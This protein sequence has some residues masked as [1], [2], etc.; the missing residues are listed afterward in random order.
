[1][2]KQN[3]SDGEKFREWTLS[4]KIPL[5]VFIEKDGKWVFCDYFNPAGPMALRD[6][7]LP[8]DLSGLSPGKIRIKLESGTSFWEIDYLAIDYTINP[9]LDIKKLSLMS[10][11]NEKDEEISEL[12]MHDD[13]KYYVQSDNSNSARLSFQ[14]IEKTLPE[15]TIILHSKGYYNLNQESKGIPRIAKLKS[16]R[17]PGQL[18]EYSRDLMKD[19]IDD[20]YK[21]Q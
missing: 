14:S 10:A 17:K 21:P 5:S 13:L 16:V 3:A 19:Y 9:V 7:V 11:F 1:L 4:Q 18:L 2:K 6:D 12:L 15:R 8:V 20:F